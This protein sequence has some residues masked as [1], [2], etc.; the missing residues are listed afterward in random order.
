MPMPTPG[1]ASLA[2]TGG[3][4]IGGVAAAAVAALL[5]SYL[6]V[7]PFGAWR[8]RSPRDRRRLRPR[9]SRLERPG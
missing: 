8:V 4:S 7:P 3:S 6:F 2:G 1:G 5:A 9:S